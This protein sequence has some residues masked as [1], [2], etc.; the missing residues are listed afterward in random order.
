MISF[1]VILKL[2]SRYNQLW[3]DIDKWKWNIQISRPREFFLQVDWDDI[4]H[5]FMVT[6]GSVGLTAACV[7]IIKLCFQYLMKLRTAWWLKTSQTITMHNVRFQVFGRLFE[8][9]PKISSR[10][11]EKGNYSS[12]IDH[13]MPNQAIS[14]IYSRPNTQN[15]ILLANIRDVSKW[16]SSNHTEGS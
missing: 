12:A 16:A 13:Y 3:S 15:S 2:Q 8:P 11:G 5:V 4:L 9:P 14:R 10:N 1:S 6:G 7:I